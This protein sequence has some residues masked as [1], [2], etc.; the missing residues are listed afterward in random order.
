MIMLPH[1]VFIR[2]SEL[3]IFKFRINSELQRAFRDYFE[4]YVN[5][6]ARCLTD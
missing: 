2:Y 1:C 4:V 5:I 6:V 3:E